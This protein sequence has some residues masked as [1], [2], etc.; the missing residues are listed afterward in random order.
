MDNPGNQQKNLNIEYQEKK[1][2]DPFRE[3]AVLGVAPSFVGNDKVR[4]GGK[5][6]WVFPETI[7]DCIISQACTGHCFYLE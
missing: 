6:C 4:K 5:T 2:D 1:D 3:L 7:Y